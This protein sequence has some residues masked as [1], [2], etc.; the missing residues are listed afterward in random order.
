[1]S[2]WRPIETA[3]KDGTSIIGGY[4][5]TPWSESHLR[6][7]IVKCWYQPEFGAFISGCREMSLAAAYSFEDGSKTRL[8]SP[9]YTPI[10]HWMP[11]PDP[12]VS[13]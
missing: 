12:P 13:E 9:E 2:E 10:T 5:H 8:H 3:P 4:F 6:G 1:M 11:L 7:Q